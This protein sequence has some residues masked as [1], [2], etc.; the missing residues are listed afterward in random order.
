V[1]STSV[2]LS[3]REDISGTTRAIFTKSLCMLPMT[4]ARSSSDRVMKSQ[5]EKV[6]LVVFVP[7]DNALYSRAFGTHTK[8]RLNRSRCRLGRLLRWALGTMC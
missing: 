6:I 4:M 1:M 2:C 5:R 8:K 3:V 7:I